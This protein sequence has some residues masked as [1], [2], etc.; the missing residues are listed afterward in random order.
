MWHVGG[1]E[2]STEDW[3]FSCRDHK[4]IIGSLVH[5]ASQIHSFFLVKN[6]TQEKTSYCRDL[7]IAD[8]ASGHV[9]LSQRSVDTFGRELASKF[10]LVTGIDLANTRR[11]YSEKSEWCVTFIHYSST[12]AA[13]GRSF[14]VLLVFWSHTMTSWKKWQRKK[15]S[16]KHGLRRVFAIFYFIYLFFFIYFTIGRKQRPPSPHPRPPKKDRLRTLSKNLFLNFSV[17]SK[18]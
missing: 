4:C 10:L 1:A 15:K 8:E 12:T 14:F 6:E 18:K 9:W 13:T 11:I 16:E 3:P 5:A 7:L 2:T 17:E